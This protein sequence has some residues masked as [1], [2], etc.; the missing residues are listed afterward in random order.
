[1]DWTS[2]GLIAIIILVVSAR[3]FLPAFLRRK[4]GHPTGDNDSQSLT[5]PLT[6]NIFVSIYGITLYLVHRVFPQ[7][8]WVQLIMLS[9]GLAISL[10]F[11]VFYRKDNL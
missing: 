10:G 8:W 2:V 5:L 4:A 11:G 7:E 3:R 9:V 6:V 1:M